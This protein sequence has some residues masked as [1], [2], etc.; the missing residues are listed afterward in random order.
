M[1][2]SPYE[3]HGTHK[4]HVFFE[5]LRVITASSVG[6]RPPL[7]ILTQLLAMVWPWCLKVRGQAGGLVSWFHVQPVECEKKQQTNERK[8]KMIIG[9]SVLPPQPLPTVHRLS[10]SDFGKKKSTTKTDKPTNRSSLYAQSS[11][12]STKLQRSH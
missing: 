3:R 6:V 1:L 11:V 5:G 2:I 7:T 10:G 4:L 8:P 12:Q 9:S